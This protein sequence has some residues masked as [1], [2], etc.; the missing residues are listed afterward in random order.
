MGYFASSATH[1]GIIII[2]FGI[3]SFLNTINLPMYLVSTR[4]QE[5]WRKQG[6]PAQTETQVLGMDWDTQS[7]EIHIEHPGI[8]RA[9]PEQ[10]A[11]KR[12]VL[13]FTS[14]FYETLGLFSPVAIVGK[15]PFQDTWTR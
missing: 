4:L 14:R 6:L 3:T 15:V 5:I 12:Q 1:D 11:T 2:F 8:T 9:L 10:P 7:D 13:Q